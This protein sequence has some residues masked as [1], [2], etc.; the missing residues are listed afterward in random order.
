MTDP[1]L[2]GKISFSC[3]GPLILVFPRALLWVVCLSLPIHLASVISS[4]SLTLSTLR[5]PKSVIPNHNSLELQ[6]HLFSSLLDIS[7]ACLTATQTQHFK[8]LFI[9]SFFFIHCFFKPSISTPQIWLCLYNTDALFTKLSETD[10]GLILDPSLFF[11]G[12]IFLAGTM[13][14]CTDSFIHPSHETYSKFIRMAV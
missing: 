6:S 8:I 11:I 14:R 2:I 3:A 12:P 13:S 7:L 10:T 5:A 9:A 1:V 4:N